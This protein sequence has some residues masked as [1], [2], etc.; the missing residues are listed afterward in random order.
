MIL[1]SSGKAAAA[2]RRN[3]KL[4]EIVRQ[5]GAGWEAPPPFRQKEPEQFPFLETSA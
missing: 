2:S 3:G 1:G 4:S 5:V